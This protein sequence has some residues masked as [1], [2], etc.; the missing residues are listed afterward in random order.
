MISVDIKNVAKIISSLIF[1]LSLTMLLPMSYAVYQLYFTKGP[2]F[3]TVEV[4]Q[5]LL[6]SMSISFILSL[7]FWAYGRDSKHTLGR[8]EA[9]LL[10]SST[11]FIGAAVA[12]LP[13]WIWAQLHDFQPLQDTGFRSYINCYFEAMSG[14]TTTGSTILSNIES[15]P[16]SLLLWRAFTHWLGGLGIVVIFVALLPSLGGGNKKLFSAEAT[17]ISNDGVTPH[18]Q[19]TTRSL[20]YIYI[21]LTLL[22]I[23]LMKI[24]DPSLSWFSSIAHSFAT[25]ATGGYSILNSS[26]GGLSAGAQW[27]III[28][29]VMAGVN[30]GLYQLLLNGKF[31]LVMK[32]SELRLYLWIIAVSSLIIFL[33]IKGTSYDISTGITAPISNHQYARDALFQVTSIQTTTGFASVNFEQW[34]IIPKF[35]LIGLM[36]VGGCGG[37]TGGG[38]KVVRVLSIFKI[39]TAEIEKSFRP[40]VIRPIKIGQHSV[41][42]NQRL[43]VLAY[44]I[45]ICIL[46]CIGTFLLLLSEK[47]ISGVTAITATISAVNNIGPG[48]EAVGAIENFS[49]FSPFGKIVLSLL[50]AIGRLEIFA[51]LVIFLPRFW[52]SE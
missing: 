42:E 52:K 20:L 48:L 39:L 26:A 25:L 29:M 32:N 7:C 11:W 17:G 38:I 43:S 40:K 12:A 1:L 23:F 47:N 46:F 9:L 3:G 5:S 8:R 51:I 21:A 14:L 28:F 45:G 10:V 35:V 41:D 16:R 24:V 34:G 6:F 50:M 19:K 49:W 27:V 36:L 15:I 44:A 31:K 33:S 18:I 4:I 30:F 37:S 13:F 2:Q 22:Q